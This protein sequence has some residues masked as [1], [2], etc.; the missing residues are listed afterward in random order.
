[1]TTNDWWINNAGGGGGGG[2]LS[3]ISPRLSTPA[4][5]RAW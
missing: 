4:A 5:A 3:Q 2:G 1:M